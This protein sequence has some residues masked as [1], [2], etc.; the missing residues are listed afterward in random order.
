MNARRKLVTLVTLVAMLLLL[1]CAP[2]SFAQATQPA[3]D[4]EAVKTRVK[5]YGLLREAFAHL[6]AAESAY[7]FDPLADDEFDATPAQEE[8]FKQAIQSAKQAIEL[9]PNLPDAHL[10]IANAYWGLGQLHQTEAHY[11]FALELDPARDDILSARVGLRIERKNLEGA[12]ADAQRLQQLESEFAESA[13]N[14]VAAAE[15]AE[16]N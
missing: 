7:E 14:E 12:K 4:M 10:L 11:S 1:C 15:Q 8:H 13:F 3:E 6:Q 5:S 2:A 16:P 9:W